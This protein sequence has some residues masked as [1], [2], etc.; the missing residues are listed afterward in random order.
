VQRTIGGLPYAVDFARLDACDYGVPQHRIRPFWFLR[1]VESEPLAWPPPTHGPIMKS[2]ASLKGTALLPWVTCA[3][4][5]GHLSAA[6]LGSP[7]RLRYREANGF[8]GRVS[9]KARASKAND[10][11][12]VVTTKPNQG[13]G[14]VLITGPSLMTAP[15][16][17]VRSAPRG[18]QTLMVTPH[19]PPSNADEPSRTVRASSSGTPC[20]T[21][22]DWPWDRP[23]TSVT[24]TDR[25]GPP[26][27]QQGSFLSS[28][29]AVKLSEKAA[30]ILQG[31]PEGRVFC[32]KT[33]A[34][35]WSQIGQAMPPPLAEAVA[36]SI[37][38]WLER[39][40]AQEVA[41]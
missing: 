32:G 33:K 35:R 10:P 34:S 8:R 25:I 31:F 11:A 5:L 36:R 14:T 9:K 19:H 1:P 7:I 4:A 39:S 26:Y 37:A 2:Q 30:A 41:R 3:Q 15:S 40:R 24:T 38:R 22:L 12:G 16:R 17:S 27:H 18:A 29:N 20:K 23:G 28:P 21:V 6:D 13:D